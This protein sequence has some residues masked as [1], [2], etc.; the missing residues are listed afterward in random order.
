M[1][2]E[3]QD[4]ETHLNLITDFTGS[5]PKMLSTTCL[6]CSIGESVVSSFGTQTKG[7]LL[8]VL[9]FRNLNNA[10]HSRIKI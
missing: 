4:L 1:I 6:G 9:R 2:E 8:G 5:L 7:V 3:S 10:V